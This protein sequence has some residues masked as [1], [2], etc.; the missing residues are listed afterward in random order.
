MMVNSK[1]EEIATVLVWPLEI[2]ASAHGNQRIAARSKEASVKWKRT[3]QAGKEWVQ[4]IELYGATLPPGNAPLRRDYLYIESCRNRQWWIREM[5]E[6]MT[7]QRAQ[8]RRK[9]RG[10]ARCRR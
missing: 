6:I 5:K 10:S 3:C 9:L 4:K 2:L 8:D 7:A 1:S